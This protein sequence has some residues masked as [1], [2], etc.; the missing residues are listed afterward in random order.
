METR[1][2]TFEEK[3]DKLLNEAKQ[4]KNVLVQQEILDAFSDDL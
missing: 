1:V 2:L 4:K 3:L